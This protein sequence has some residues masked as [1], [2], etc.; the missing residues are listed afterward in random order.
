[1]IP[2]RPAVGLH[3]RFGVLRERWRDVVSGS[4]IV[5]ALALAI[6]PASSHAQAVAA[7]PAS[8]LAAAAAEARASGGTAATRRVTTVS[9][10]A[11]GTGVTAGLTVATGLVMFFTPAGSSDGQ[12]HWRGGILFDEAAR[13]GLRL[14]APGDRDIAAGVS[15]LMLTLTMLNATV[16]DAGVIPLVQG[17]PDLAWQAS[18]AHGLALGLM[19]TVGEAA[20]LAVG[21]AR[22]YERECASDPS[23]PGCQSEDRFASF[24]SLH[25]GMAFTSAGFSCS[26]H[27]ARSL[28]GDAGA[29][30][31][32]CAA[33]IGA[34]SATGLLRVASD[35]HYVSD[36]IVG[37][38][39][40]F[41]IG[42]VVPL[43]VV[44]ERVT[45]ALP[46]PE[47]EPVAP[48]GEAIPAPT[49]GGFVAAVP[50]I[51]APSAAGTD[52]PSTVGVS[53]TGAF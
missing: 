20:K 53:V 12:G 26:M 48:E 2:R 11:T 13:D 22:P 19:L 21:R 16:L 39:L 42:Y 17:D 41:A 8:Q 45:I 30:I 37:A 9:R 25:T 43:I 29:D 31:A 49:P 3:A 7:G 24:F 40:G 27:L 10:H 18:L 51:G 14:R 28:Y 35:R 33:A 1:M 6:A 38:L 50:M 36:V 4:S 32:T 5:C 44:P 46:D 34:A 15:D 52:G 23:A 47:G